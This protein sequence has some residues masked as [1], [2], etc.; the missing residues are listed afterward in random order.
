MSDKVARYG[1]AAICAA[2]AVYLMANS[3]D[4]WGWLVFLAVLTAT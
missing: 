3:A 1:F 4:G 2:G